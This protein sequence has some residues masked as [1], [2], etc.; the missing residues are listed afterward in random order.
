MTRIAIAAI[1]L[2]LSALPAY[3]EKH[4]VTVNGTEKKPRWHFVNDGNGEGCFT[5]DCGIEK[6]APPFAGDASAWLGVDN[7]GENPNKRPMLFM[8]LKSKS[9]KKIRALGYAAYVMPSSS[10]HRAPVL[11]INIDL[12]LKDA[13]NSY[14]GRLVFDPANQT[15]TQPIVEGEWQFWQA[16]SQDALWYL[17][18]T[19]DDVINPCIETSPCTLRQIID[20]H[21]HAGIHRTFGGI[22][23]YVGGWG[24]EQIETSVD[25]ITV[26]IKKKTVT[27]NFESGA[28][29]SSRSCQDGGWSG[30]YDDVTDCVSH[31]DSLAENEA[32]IQDDEEDGSEL[33]PASYK[34]CRRNG[35]VGYFGSEAQCVGYFRP[36]N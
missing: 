10:Q 29:T 23:I 12:D 4:L 5:P 21:P 32:Q 14:Q 28:P 20:L 6:Y 1:T 17:T 33:P 15:L 18:E 7:V 2:V 19:P 24:L 11:V 25:W 31:F 36:R 22:G 16:L 13:D 3:A 30:Y 9:L 35:W 8:P 26:G 27:Y 34:D